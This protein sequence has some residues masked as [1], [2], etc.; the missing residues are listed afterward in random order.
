MKKLTKYN[1]SVQI[2][3]AYTRVKTARFLNGFTIDNKGNTNLFWNQAL[4]APGQSVAIGGNE[5][6]VYDGII[7]LNFALPT[8][9]PPVPVNLAQVLQKYFT[10]IDPYDP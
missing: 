7:E 6:E 9:A 1:V 10:Q 4:I 2:Y 3:T 8:P 5:G